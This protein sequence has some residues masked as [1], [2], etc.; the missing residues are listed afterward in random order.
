MSLDDPKAAPGSRP[1][2]G[3]LYLSQT[4]RALDADRSSDV[5]IAL[6]V[7]GPPSLAR[8]TQHLAH[9]AAPEFNR[10]TDWN[11]QI[12]FEPGAILEYEQ[13]RRVVLTGDGPIGVDFI[14][15]FGFSAGNVLTAAE[16]GFRARAGW[17]LSHPWL[18]EHHEAEIALAGGLS[19]RAVARDI[20]LDGNSFGNSPRVGHKPFIGAGELGLEIRYGA[21]TLGYRAVNETRAWARGPSWHPWASMVGA[22]TY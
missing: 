2:G 7:T 18:L 14:P 5:T 17:H 6:G 8:F 15:R 19:G 13:Q 10:P 16:A 1:N 21:L 22:V 11:E 12:H 9:Q 3:W 20:F 4:A